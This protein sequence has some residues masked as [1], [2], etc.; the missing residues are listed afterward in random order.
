MAAEWLWARLLFLI[1]VCGLAPH[2]AR[3]Q[4]VAEPA[5]DAEKKEQQRVAK[6]EPQIKAFEEQ[7]AKNPPPAGGVVFVGSSSIRLW[8]LADSFPQLAA[9]NRGFGGS[10]LADSVHYA[11]RIVTKLK[12][13]VVVLYAGDNDL[14]SG[15][16]PQRVAGDFEAFVK[17]VHAKLPHTKIVYIGIKPSLA[18]WKL[19]DKIREANRR[20]KDV[21]ANYDRVVCIDAEAPMLNAEGQPRAELFAKDGL[22]LSPEGYQVWARLIRPQLNP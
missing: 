22:H 15:K 11:E 6:W 1:L 8:K 7:D 3:A 10:Q 21:A 4:A 20:I 12:P 9:I 5:S 14:A 2:L 17:Q 19:I 18:R 16:T 13:R